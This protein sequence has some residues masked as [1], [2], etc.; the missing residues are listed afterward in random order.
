MRIVLTRLIDLIEV[1]FG[2]HALENLTRV[3]LRALQQGSIVTEQLLGELE[4]DEVVATAEGLDVGHGNDMTPSQNLQG[5]QTF[6]F[7]FEHK[8]DAQV[9]VDIGSHIGRLLQQLQ[10]NAAPPFVSFLLKEKEGDLHFLVGE[11]EVGAVTDDNTIQSIENT[12]PNGVE[13]A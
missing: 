6:D 5:K 3:G 2:I 1:H 7:G 9:I 11:V 8:P 10:K 12:R 4:I 13:V